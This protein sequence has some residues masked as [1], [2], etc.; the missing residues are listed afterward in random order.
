[1]IQKCYKKQ[2]KRRKQTKL[3][4]KRNMY[5]HNTE[6]DTINLKTKRAGVKM[7]SS[8]RRREIQSGEDRNIFNEYDDDGPVVITPVMCINICTLLI[9]WFVIILYLLYIYICVH[10]YKKLS[11]ICFWF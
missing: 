1:L 4:P 9:I 2:H 8:L 6:Q 11:R 3:E 5:E 7:V 10:V